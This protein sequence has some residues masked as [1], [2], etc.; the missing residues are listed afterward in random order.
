MS[1][2][3]CIYNEPEQMLLILTV[4]QKWLLPDH[5]AYL[6]SNIVWHLDLPVS[7]ACY[8]SKEREYP[9]YHHRTSITVLLYACYVGL[10]LSRKIERRLYEDIAFRVLAA[11]ITHDFH[12]Y[13]AVLT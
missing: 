11:N 1:K 12:T 2:A 13:F 6:I 4:L 8:D 9:P 7:M 3:F 10:T 5:L